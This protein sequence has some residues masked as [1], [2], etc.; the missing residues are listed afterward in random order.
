MLSNT[1]L[2]QVKSLFNKLSPKDEFEIMFNN[3]KTDNKLSIIKF[4]DALKYLK[5]RSD[6]DK[7]EL[8][9]ETTL[10][11]GYTYENQNIYRISIEGNEMIN[12]ILNLVHQRKNHIVFSILVTQ[13]LK[14][15][16]FTFMNKTKD[17][18]SYIDV[19]EF[20]IRFRKSTEDE[21]D[22]KKLK[23]LSNVPINDSDK[24]FYR[25]KQR[26]SLKI[27]DSK[28]EKI[29]ID[30]TIIKTSNNPNDLQSAPKSY[31]L[32]IDF[33]GKPSEKSLDTIIKEVQM[34]KQVIEGSH[35]LITKEEGKK[36]ID[37]YK[38]L[39]FG[40]TIE[41]PT[42]LYSMQPISAEV[43][44]VIDKIPNRYS[45]TDKADGEKYQMLITNGSIYLISNN[46]NVKKI[47][48][49][50]KDLDDTIIEGELIHLVSKKKYLF[51][52]FDCLMFKGK[53]LR[54]ETNLQ[55]R[56]KGIEDTLGKL[57]SK[58]YISKPFSG[59]YDME[60]Q[61]KHYTTELENF[62]QNL[63]KLIDDTEES[64][65][66]FHPKM[67]IFPTGGSNSEVYLYAYLIWFA[68]TNSTKVNCPY[69]LDGVIFTALDQKYTR[70]KREQKYPIYKFKPP[71]TN[72]IDIYMN[73]QRNPETGGYLEIYDN[74]LPIKSGSNSSAEQ[75]YRVANFYVGDLV[76][77]KEVPVPFM[78]EENNHEAFFPLVRGEVRDI[79]GNFIQDNT[80]I[81]VIYSNNTNVPHQYRWSILRTRWDKTETV[82]REQKRYGNF[83]DTAIKTWKS[84]REAVTIEEIK[85]LSNVDSYPSQLKIL[86]GRIDS[87][88]ITSD[89]AQD[90]YYQNITNLCKSMR[91]FQNWIKSILIYTYC[92]P[93]SK[94]KGEKPTKASILDIGC[95]RGGDILKMYHARVGD[96]VGIDP[97]YEGL[98]AATDSAVSR[99]N[100][101]KSKFP[102]FGKMV[103]IQ[104]DGSLPLKAD[105][106]SKRLSNMSQDNKNNITK[107]FDSKRKFD[108]ITSMF[109]IHYLFNSLDSVNNLI[110]NIKTYLNVGGY[111]VFTLFDSGKVMELLGEKDVFTSYFTDDNGEKQKLFEIVKKFTGPVKDEPGQTIDVSMRWISEAYY[112][113]NLI[114]PKLM[115]KSMEKA[116]CRLV[117]SDLFANLYQIN[118]GWFTDVISH[119]ENVKN[120]EFYNN[121]AKFYGELKGAD[122]EAKN[123]S[124]LNRYYIFQKME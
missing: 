39:T 75:V 64:G 1:V 65:Y 8:V 33:M 57:Q 123:F 97:D 116:G 107:Y 58:I 14:D 35:D 81:E 51:M 111:I 72:S 104:A 47:G 50:V 84:M 27:L 122:K 55:V 34:L 23:E 43:Q 32:E 69:L 74:S 118:K 20:D 61:E 21:I 9:S 3:Y 42:N 91:E 79:E 44:H 38:K 46:L 16:H 63:N 67:F 36:V 25:Y 30:L 7:L 22:S 115:I 31:E 120:K 109:A 78:K 59:K 60:K 73:F 76:G 19:D 80:V 110:T 77:N 62:Y 10:D 13:F 15:E 24:I 85:K 28:D 71:E 98:F 49:K 113:E 18:K 41:T 68:C 66:I 89:R 90:K 37:I 100:F 83:K 99:Y 52:G 53:D 45:A 101:T 112:P 5:W 103:Y 6:T 4:M 108:V 117:D 121:V 40:T 119:E 56:L 124:F 12:N 11:V 96:Y 106:Q 92:Q 102:D 29:Q 88:V 54:N 70:D 86:Q 105:I 2:T 17:N 114:T 82:L 26:V 87:S 94:N 48:K 93:F 95:G